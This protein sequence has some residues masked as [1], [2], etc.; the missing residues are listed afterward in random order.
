M[1]TKN[2]SDFVSRLRN[3]SYITLYVRRISI[4]IVMLNSLMVEACDR[5][6]ASI[7]FMSFKIMP[8]LHYEVINKL[9]LSFVS[10]V[11]LDA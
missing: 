11:V 6:A 1:K 2:D 4:A 9:F 7:F 10:C 3:W 8:A 5:H